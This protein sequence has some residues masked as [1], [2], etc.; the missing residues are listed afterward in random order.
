MI[1]LEKYI[2]K[3]L[4]KPRTV[5]YYIGSEEVYLKKDVDA[6]LKLRDITGDGG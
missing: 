3:D 6:Y 4:F 1:D 5:T 2:A